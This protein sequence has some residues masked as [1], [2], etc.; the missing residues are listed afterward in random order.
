[1]RRAATVPKPR[2]NRE[3]LRAKPLRRKRRQVETEPAGPGAPWDAP[4]PAE[5]L[6]PAP[7]PTAQR[8]AP[9]RRATAEPEAESSVGPERSS[10]ARSLALARR[11]GESLCGAAIEAPDSHGLAWLSR[12]RGGV[13]LPCRDLYNG[14]AGVLV[15]LAELAA[16]LSEPRFSEVVSAGMASLLA[17]QSADPQ[18]LPS[19]FVGEAG[20]GA[21]L[22][23]CGQLLGRQEW[24]DAAAERGRWVA[25]R[26]FVAPDLVL[27]TAGRL[28]FHLWLA[29]ET[30]DP[31]PLGHAVA[32]GEALLAAAEEAPYGGLFWTLPPGFDSL[33]GRAFP[34]YGHGAAGIGEALLDLY[35]AT[36]DDRFLDAAC[37]A[38]LWVESLALPTLGDGCGLGWPAWEGRA[39]SSSW[40]YGAPGV[41]LFFLRL[42]ASGVYPE[43][44]ELAVSAGRAATCAARWDDPTLCH[45]LAG[46]LDLLLDLAQARG[47]S[48][49]E[50]EAAWVSEARA[51]GEIQA[52]GLVE[53]EGRLALSADPPGRPTPGLMV[54]IAGVAMSALRLADP[55]RRP[56][57]LSSRG[58]RF[59]P[60]AESD[61]AT[62]IP[63]PG[64]AL[65]WLAPRP[66]AVGGFPSPPI[67]A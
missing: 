32:A 22:L 64:A 46:N 6:A 59:R 43:A 15:A 18:P 66:R 14:R 5:Q 3:A 47:I 38:A 44:A 36:G 56:R 4:L 33:F 13:L 1:M 24:I 42:A 63:A 67:P 20:V 2:T 52:E 53:R 9:G 28:R 19:L 39:V 49:L 26:P 45:G 27:G 60:R 30:G 8:H 58:F 29:E 21:A 31:E 7:G 35:E 12:H 11:L 57:L 51:L 17:G 65:P 61:L 50:T 34:G 16:E 37:A 41:G 55:E 48:D 23:R 62:T 10:R 25:G 40:C 54:G